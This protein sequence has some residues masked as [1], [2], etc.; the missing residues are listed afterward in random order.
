[1]WP[2]CDHVGCGFC[3]HPCGL[4]GT[5][6]DVACGGIGAGFLACEMWPVRAFVRPSCELVGCG[7]WW[8]SCWLRVS[9]WGCRACKGIHAGLCGL[10]VTCVW[11]FGLQ[12][13]S[14]TSSFGQEPPS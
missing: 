1:M 8:R 6:Q 12:H 2:P 3:G 10:C 5:L 9:F 4:C 14:Y 13:R 7:L 11:A